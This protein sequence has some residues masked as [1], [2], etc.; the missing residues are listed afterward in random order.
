MAALVARQIVEF[1]Y[2]FDYFTARDEYASEVQAEAA[3]ADLL[4]R[5]PE[6]IVAYLESFGMPTADHLIE[7]IASLA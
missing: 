5:H 7:R 3:V 4:A 1:V 2:E 6:A